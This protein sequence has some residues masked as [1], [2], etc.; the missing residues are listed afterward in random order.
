MPKL[1]ALRT[2]ESIPGA[3]TGLTFVNPLLVRF[4]RASAANT[5]I[6][7]DAQHTL[8]I[9]EPVEQV[10]AAIDTALGQ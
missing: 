1:C 3:G 6:Y 4:I 5:V 8:N 10:Q 7:F 2:V 9:A